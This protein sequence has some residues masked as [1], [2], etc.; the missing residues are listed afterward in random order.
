M[1][2][3]NEPTVQQILGNDLYSYFKE[4]DENAEKVYFTDENAKNKESDSENSVVKIGLTTKQAIDRIISKLTE[5]LSNYNDKIKLKDL[6]PELVQVD[7]ALNAT[8]LLI[9]I[10]KMFAN[11]YWEFVLE[12][13]L[14][15]FWLILNVYVKILFKVSKVYRKRNRLLEILHF[16]K[17]EFTYPNPESDT[18]KYNIDPSSSDFISVYRDYDWVRLPR[19]ILVEGDVYKLR[20][21]ETFPCDSLLILN[22]NNN[23]LVTHNEIYREGERCNFVGTPVENE[24]FLD[25]TFVALSDSFLK[26]I[27]YYLFHDHSDYQPNLELPRRE[28]SWFRNNQEETK[29]IWNYN[30]NYIFLNNNNKIVIVI[31]IIVTLILNLMWAILYNVE[32]K[33]STII[34]MYRLL[35]M[36]QFVG[37]DPFSKLS[38]LWGNVK[39]M[40]IFD[41]YQENMLKDLNPVRSVSSSKSLLSSSIFGSESSDMMLS[42]VKISFMQVNKVLR[43]GLF[44]ELSLIRRLSTIT[45]LSFIDDVGILLNSYQSLQEISIISKNT[46]NTTI[47]SHLHES[48]HH[49]ENSQQDDGVFIRLSTTDERDSAL[50]MANILG[51]VFEQDVVEDTDELLILDIYNDIDLYGKDNSAFINDYELNNK[52]LLKPLVFS[53]ALTSILNINMYRSSL[54]NSYMSMLINNELA[55]YTNCLCNLNTV[56]N[57]RRYYLKH[58]KLLK[59]IVINTS[60]I[61]YSTDIKSGALDSNDDSIVIYFYRDLNKR[62]IQMLIKCRITILNDCKLN[63]YN[64]NVIKPLNRALRRKISDLNVQWLSNGIGSFLYLYKPISIDDYNILQVLLPFSTIYNNFKTPPTTNVGNTGPATAPYTATAQTGTETGFGTR[65]KNNK[66]MFLYRHNSLYYKYKGINIYKLSNK[67]KNTISSEALAHKDIILG[68]FIGEMLKSYIKNSILLGIVGIKYEANKEINSKINE[69]HKSGIRFVYFSKHNEKHTR[70][71]GSLFGLEIS[72]N[73]MISLSTSET[74]SYINQEGHIVLPNGIDNIRQHIKYV[75]DIPLQVSLFC[76][77]NYENIIEMFNIL[78]ENNEN[79]MCIGSGLNSNNF[80]L[81]SNAYLAFAISLNYHP[82]CKFC[83]CKRWQGVSRQHVIVESRSEIINEGDS[84]FELLFELFKESRNTSTNIQEAVSFMLLSYYTIITMYFIQSLLSLTSVFNNFDLILIM[85]FY[86]PLIS[87]TLLNNPIMDKIMEQL[88]NKIESSNIYYKY[89]FRIYSRIVVFALFTMA[90][91][92]INIFYVNNHLNATF[93]LN[94]QPCKNFFHYP[95]THCMNLLSKHLNYSQYVWLIQNFT[96]I[97]FVIFLIISSIFWIQKYTFLGIS[98]FLNYHWLFIS[99][100]ICFVH[101][102][103]VSLRLY[104]NPIE[105]FKVI[106]ILITNSSLSLLFI[107]PILLIDQAIKLFIIKDKNTQQKFLQLLFSTKLGTWSPK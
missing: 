71:I 84:L 78:N 74:S 93:M 53:I 73:S 104:L 82:L 102:G 46:Q 59:F 35:I 25:G 66:L 14:L 79:I 89:Y 91:H 33:F 15:L 80:Y 18:K 9:N 86:I 65:R 17:F 36:L 92:Y 43:L 60:G 98:C 94:N 24:H 44:D 29:I 100:L 48:I 88:P 58:F 38:E 63:F 67:F 8:A 32:S 96:S 83:K 70:I 27:N 7:I 49:H 69:L 47:S 39:L 13:L 40:A 6:F 101:V 34:T 16:L 2:Y 103:I 77:C 11:V 1:E 64:G 105:D 37:L 5:I 51:N 19:N 57:F 54:F 22:V 61:T 87:I 31:I 56:F 55:S 75:D 42:E 30:D 81:F 23:D 85:Y 26:Y 50:N 3:L 97:V 12:F 45:L 20:I 107:V 21:N 72:W 52:N 28:S 106:R 95:K 76:N 90:T 41:L 68:S 10:G 62:V 99:F 4:S